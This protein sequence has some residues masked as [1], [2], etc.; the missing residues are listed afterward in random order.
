[1]AD[2]ILKFVKAVAAL[3]SP[4]SANTFYSVRVGEGFDMY[5]TDTTGSMAFKL[6]G[7]NGG[8]GGSGG[9]GG[10]IQPS[11]VAGQVLT[12]QNVNGVMT[13]VWANPDES[14]GT[15]LAF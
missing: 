11:S 3:P 13:L 2:K 8:S 12:T 10:G 6:N 9:S 4:L 14:I 1:M 7:G 15:T 5:L